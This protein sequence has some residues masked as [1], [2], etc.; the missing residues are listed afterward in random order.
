M[1]TKIIQLLCFHYWFD[2]LRTPMSVTEQ[3]KLA[4]QNNDKINVFDGI[5]VDENE[6]EYYDVVKQC[7]KCGKVHQFQD[8]E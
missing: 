3:F 2:L 1:K 8:W 6:A 5:P 4:L 7:S